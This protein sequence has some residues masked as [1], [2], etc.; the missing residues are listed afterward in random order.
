MTKERDQAAISATT[1]ELETAIITEISQRLCRRLA[2]GVAS[3]PTAQAILEQLA[4]K[5]TL[6][7]E[8]LHS[9]E[10]RRIAHPADGA[11][12]RRSAHPRRYAVRNEI[13]S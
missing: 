3:K 8:F 2:R 11:R 9:L 12:V 10:S 4:M 13:R 6:C 1:R 7:D 5:L